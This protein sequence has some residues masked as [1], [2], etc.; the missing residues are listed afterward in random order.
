[1]CGIFLKGSSLRLFTVTDSTTITTRI[2]SNRTYK[3]LKRITE[4]SIGMQKPWIMKR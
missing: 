4:K 2:I 3:T 1:L